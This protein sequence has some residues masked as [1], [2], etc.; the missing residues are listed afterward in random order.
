MLHGVISHQQ[1]RKQPV[2]VELF[3]QDELGDYFYI[4]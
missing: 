4:F 2:T 1:I 3:L